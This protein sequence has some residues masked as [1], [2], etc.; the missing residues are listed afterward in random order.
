VT[1]VEGDASRLDP[2]WSA[3][4]AAVVSVFGLQQLPEPDVAIASWAAAL[5]PGGRLS[6][7]FWPDAA[8]SEGPF[9]LMDD[10]LRPHVPPVD[11]S[12][13]HR[14]GPALSAT[15]VVIDRD[16]DLSYPM[17][18]RSASAIFDAYTRHGPGR[19]LAMARGDAFIGQVRRE[20]LR[21]APA[22]EWQHRPRARLLVAHR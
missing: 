8:E 16:E 3:R 12:W 10:V 19:A 13:E 18:H 1:V 14:L 11:S 22:G 15:G 4:C 7:V 17:A 5:R 9:A 20:F 2:Q 21:R 6:V